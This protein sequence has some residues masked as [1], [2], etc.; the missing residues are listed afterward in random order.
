MNDQI[1]NCVPPPNPNTTNVC[2]G[3]G[4]RYELPGFCTISTGAGNS[5]RD[6]WCEKLGSP[7][8]WEVYGNS[9]SCTYNICYPY[10]DDNKECTNGNKSCPIQ[11]GDGVICQRVGY[12]GDP[13]TCCLND[14]DCNGENNLCFSDS[15]MKNTCDPNYRNVAEG[16]CPQVI[17][18]YCSGTLPTDDY[19]NTDWINRW[20]NPDGSEVPNSCLYALQRNIF[21]TGACTTGPPITGNCNENLPELSS[22]GVAV[23]Q[24]L[25]AQVLQHYKD[26]GFVIGSLPGSVT[27]NPLQDFLY[28]NVC[29]PYSILCQNGLNNICNS[30][31]SQQASL[32]PSI[33]NWC[34]CYLDQTQYETY[35][36][37]YNIPTSCT[38]VCNRASAIPLVS[39]NGEPIKCEIDICLIDNITVN[40]ANSQINGGIDIT[41]I[42]GNCGPNAQCSC[43]IDNDTID[44]N[45]SFITGNVSINESC[46]NFICPQPQDLPGVSTYVPIPCN[47]SSNPFEQYEQNVTIAQETASQRSY[48]WTI[49]IVIIILLI[50]IMLFFFLR[51]TRK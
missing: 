25:M 10:A 31:T 6:A 50:I 51:P 14:Y 47:S 1:N 38:P 11:Y 5:I 45:N 36:A 8:E 49:L 42:C 26:N 43:I 37:R 23:G 33:G 21:N 44:I 16:G 15:A 34:G 40:I 13:V 35:S 17:I 20:I 4:E 24:Q 46:G 3:Y 7:G 30:F 28:S 32:V 48:F 29:C 27:Y 19:S 9:K 18:E 41:Q 39:G 2:N 12:N 22:Q